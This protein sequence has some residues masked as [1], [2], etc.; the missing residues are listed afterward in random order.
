MTMD[1]SYTFC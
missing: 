1:R